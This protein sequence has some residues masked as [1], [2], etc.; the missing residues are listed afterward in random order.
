[1]RAATGLKSMMS[2]PKCINH[3]DYKVRF[4]KVLVGRT[5]LTTMSKMENE[6]NVDEFDRLKEM[7]IPPLN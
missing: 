1:M 7:S 3:T 6:T 5:G 4:R 2:D